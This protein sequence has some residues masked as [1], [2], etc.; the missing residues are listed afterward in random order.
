MSGVRERRVDVEGISTRYLEAGEPGS[1]TMVL[2]HGGEFGSYALAEDWMPVIPLLARRFHVV[3]PDLLGCG[4]T[5]GPAS[6]DE[7][8][9]SR[10]AD[11]ADALLRILGIATTH[12]VGHS[13]GGFVATLLALG[14]PSVQSLGIVGG[15]TL[16]TPPNPIYGEWAE[17]GAA[18]AD[19]RERVRHLVEVN[20][21]S[22]DHIDEEFVTSMSEAIGTPGSLRLQE[23]FSGA[24]RERFHAELAELAAETRERIRGGELAAPTLVT[25]G[26]R[27]PS[28]LIDVAGAASMDLFLGSVPHA[29]MHVFNDAGHYSFRERPAEFVSVTMAFID[30]N[31]MIYTYP[32]TDPDSRDKRAE[33][34]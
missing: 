28:A 2:L 5:D 27:D 16:V 19:P 22:G 17:Q 26:Y 1:P 10:V 33:G 23:Q 4:F 13:R 18:I 31:A 14:N 21:H 30:S 15:G 6:P 11:H 24:V 34:A 20:S 12:L 3:V 9:L 25:W 29:S 7:L 8:L 32:P